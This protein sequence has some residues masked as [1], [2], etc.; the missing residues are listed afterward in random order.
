MD[1]KGF[2]NYERIF[3]AMGRFID[4]EKWVHVCVMEFEDGFVLQGR[5]FVDTTESYALVTR[6]K[7]LGHEELRDLIA[8]VG[9]E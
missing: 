9:A 2:T 8:S 3:T 7:V 1:L 6:T 5:T 4:R